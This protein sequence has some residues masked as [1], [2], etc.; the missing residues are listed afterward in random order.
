MDQPRDVLRIATFQPLS[1][2]RREESAEGGTVRRSTNDES[3][4]ALLRPDLR[5][6][7]ADNPGNFFRVPSHNAPDPGDAG[8]AQTY[9]EIG[10]RILAQ[11]HAAPD[12]I[13]RFRQDLRVSILTGTG[14]PADPHT[15]DG[16]NLPESLTPH[17]PRT[18]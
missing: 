2:Q 6:Q 10:L 12:A 8:P 3:N 9:G 14:I 7:Q 5:T 15:G 16:K 13:L 11:P 17:R 18:K 1:L 4:V